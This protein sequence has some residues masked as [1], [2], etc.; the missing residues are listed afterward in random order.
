MTPKRIDKTPS[1][2][3]FDELTEGMTALAEARQDKRTLPTHPDLKADLGRKG[4]K[5]KKGA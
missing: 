4:P 5:K 2:D 3:L 1:R